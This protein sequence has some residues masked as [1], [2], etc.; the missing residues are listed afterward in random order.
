MR[1]ALA[2]F[3]QSLVAE[4]KQAIR[5]GIGVNTGNVV[6]GNIGSEERLEYTII[7]DAV[8]TTQR[9]QDLTKEFMTDVLIT[10]STYE[11]VKDLIE[12]GVPHSV[13]IRGRTRATAIYP[14]IGFK[15]N[16]TQPA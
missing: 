15:A 13:T 1:E 4:G 11:R 10:E 3:N 5:I 9:T 8:N 7:G 2:D 14:V 6:I 12:V 16:I